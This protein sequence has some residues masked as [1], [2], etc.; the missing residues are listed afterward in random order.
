MRVN[1]RLG[2]RD[3]LAALRLARV[4]GPFSPVIAGLD[5]AIHPLREKHFCEP[6]LERAFAKKMDPRVK[7]AGDDVGLHRVTPRPRVPDECSERTCASGTRSG[8]QR[9]KREAQY[10]NKRAAS[11]VWPLLGWTARDGI[12]VP[13]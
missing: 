10:R 7:P 8:T 5:P 1:M 4:S 2:I 12:S 9:K 11:V 13:E 6:V 3:A